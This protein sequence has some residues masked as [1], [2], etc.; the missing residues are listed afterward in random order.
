MT[1]GRSWA[2]EE[3]DQLR[4]LAAANRD[5]GAVAR[6][7]NRTEAAVIGRAYKLSVQFGKPKTRGLGARK[8]K[9]PLRNETLMLAIASGLLAWLLTVALKAAI[10]GESTVEL[11]TEGEGKMSISDPRSQPPRAHRFRCP[12]DFS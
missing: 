9:N 3:D 12:R 1:A 11:G 4:T 7:L 6:E 10:S 2:P 8:L 5:L